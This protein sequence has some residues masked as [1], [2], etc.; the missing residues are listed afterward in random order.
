MNKNVLVKLTL[1]I[2][3]SIGNIMA[4]NYTAPTKEIPNKVNIPISYENVKES[5]DKIDNLII[6]KEEFKED[7]IKV[8]TTLT[9][10]KKELEALIKE[11][12]SN[13]FING[14]ENISIE[15]VQE[16]WKWSGVIIFNSYVEYRNLHK[17]E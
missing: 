9:G 3:F 1:L 14:V 12:N 4:I 16:N 13:K 15:K 6:E 7:I 2:I 17:N 8:S 11:I 10:E 5:L